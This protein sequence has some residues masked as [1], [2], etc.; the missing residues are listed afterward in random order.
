MSTAPVE[1]QTSPGQQQVTPERIMQICWGFAPPLI[2]ES[3]IRYRL[4]DVVD[5]APKD[6]AE[7]CKE[8]GTNVRATRAVADALV[9]L[10]LLTKDKSGRYSTT[11]ESS[12]FLVSSKPSFTGGIFRHVS[13]QLVPPFLRLPE[14]MHAGSPAD[15]VNKEAL[16]TEFF[17]DL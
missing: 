14:I 12:V 4:F 1:P 5:T 7:I 9:G 11:P 16:G 10:N 17:K 15:A 13:N 2:I 8:T 6:L 3:A